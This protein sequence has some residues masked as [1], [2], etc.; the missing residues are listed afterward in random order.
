LLLQLR[1]F[2][3]HV[4]NPLFPTRHLQHGSVE[5]RA[6]PHVLGLQSRGGVLAFLQ[7]AALRGELSLQ[8]WDDGDGLL[9]DLLLQQLHAEARLP[10][11]ELLDGAQQVG[12]LRRGARRLH[13]SRRAREVHA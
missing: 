13:L 2:L 7:L 3:L 6:Q 12:D 8:E 5:L 9:Q 10:L 11:L 1:H 4:N